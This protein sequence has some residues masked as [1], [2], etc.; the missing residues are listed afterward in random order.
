MGNKSIELDSGFISFNGCE[1]IPVKDAKI[2][3][4]T[5]ND[6]KSDFKY[7]ELHDTSAEFTATIRLKFWSMVKL[8]GFKH[9]VKF[10][11]KSLCRRKRNEE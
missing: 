7:I 5:E 2:S 6:V 10:K 9:A 4:A 11:L 8:F 3:D 1:A